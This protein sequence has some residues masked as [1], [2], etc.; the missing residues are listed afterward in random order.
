ML[1]VIPRSPSPIPLEDRPIG[2]L[3]VDE[4][5]ELVRRQRAQIIQSH[6]NIKNEDGT[7]PVV[8]KEK[9]DQNTGHNVPDNDDSS[10]IEVVE[11]ASRK[12]KIEV[13]ELS[14]GE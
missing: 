10:D 3:S 1:G 4:L 11:V 7:K 9:R 5:H 6:N 12:R 13:V 2:E 8:K 14:D